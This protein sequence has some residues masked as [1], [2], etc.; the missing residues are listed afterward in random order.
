MPNNTG[1]GSYPAS[2]SYSGSY[3]GSGSLPSGVAPASNGS[4]PWAWNT[5]TGSALP[6][7]QPSLPMPSNTG[8]PLTGTG[9]VYP[10]SAPPFP[11]RPSEP[12]VLPPAL[13]AL[14]LSIL[15]AVVIGCVVAF[16][17]LGLLRKYQDFQ[18]AASAQQVVILVAKAD[19]A[20]NAADYKQAAQLLEQALAAQ[21]DPQERAKI[22]TELGYT[23]VQLGRI[24]RKQGDVAGAQQD[25]ERAIQYSPGY[26]T[27]HAELAQLLESQGDH[28][29]AQQEQSLSSSNTQ[30]APPK[31]DNS[32]QPISG[33]LATG[34]TSGS[35]D[36]GNP[37]ADAN[38]FY[39]QRQAKARQL[40]QDGDQLYASGDKYGAEQKWEQAEEQAPSFPEGQ[41][42]RQRLDQFHG[43][44][45][46][47][48]GGLP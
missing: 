43:V 13:R 4:L 7:G 25:Y 30:D 10:Y 3:M 8:G 14:L 9:G 17:V 6:S 23:Y 21:P 31:L 46:G 22:F 24:V 47:D 28:A 1:M 34:D 48:S 29:G 20:Y 16:L 32:T 19:A 44:T 15:T 27:A 5:S 33:T 41:A 36:T 12:F 39:E 26:G 2:G 45:G 18:A 38:Q 40:L 37:S 35:G 11:A 42:A